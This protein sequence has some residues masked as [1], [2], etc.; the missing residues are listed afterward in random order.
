MCS[1]E[2][3]VSPRRVRPVSRCVSVV[4][5]IHI[6]GIGSRFCGVVLL[7]TQ[8]KCVN[9]RETR[10]IVLRRASLGVC[11]VTEQQQTV[12][13]VGESAAVRDS[14]GVCTRRPSTLRCPSGRLPSS[15]ETRRCSL[16]F[17]SWR[18]AAPSLRS[19]TAASEP[20]EEPRRD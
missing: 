17:P 6:F 18:G 11:S 12:F 4:W 20:F 3:S 5:D 14:Y 15:P 7:L 9:G 19:A 2:R 8:R 16:F 10:P 1:K 13:V